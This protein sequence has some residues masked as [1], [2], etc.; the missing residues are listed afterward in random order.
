MN[1]V[2]ESISA[3]SVT[4]EQTL[5]EMAAHGPSADYYNILEVQ[6]HTQ[7]VLHKEGGTFS[8]VHL[9]ICVY[10]IYIK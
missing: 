7:I 3:V 9:S 5:T 4:C 1:P 6:S 2:L 8:N 10:Y